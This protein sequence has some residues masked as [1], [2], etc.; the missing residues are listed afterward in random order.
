MCEN[1]DNRSTQK[2]P[3][4][5]ILFS[6]LAEKYEYSLNFIIFLKYERYFTIKII[7]KTAINKNILLNLFWIP[8]QY[9]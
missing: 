4:D 9:K 7:F 3:L 1:E 6:V 2:K 5:Y 8:K